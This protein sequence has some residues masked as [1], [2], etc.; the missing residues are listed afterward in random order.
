LATSFGMRHSFTRIA[1]SRARAHAAYCRFVDATSIAAFDESLSST[2]TVLGTEQFVASI[3]AAAVGRK[4]KQSLAD[5][6]AQACVKFAISPA[7]LM[8]ARR[9]PGKS[10]GRG[11]G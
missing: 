5:L 3:S 9:E 11:P 1:G 8:S 7:L 10:S 2:A 4:P 6:A